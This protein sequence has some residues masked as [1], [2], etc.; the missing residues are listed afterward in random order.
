MVCDL[1]LNDLHPPCVSFA[2][3][4]LKIL[5]GAEMLI[6]AVHVRCAVAVVSGGR[7][8]LA[9]TWFGM[10]F[11]QIGFIVIIVDWSSPDGRSAETLDVIEAIGDAAKIASVVVAGLGSIVDRW[12]FFRGV[13]CWVT[14]AESIGHQKVNKVVCI[15]TLWLM[16]NCWEYF[17]GELGQGGFFGGAMKSDGENTWGTFGSDV[18]VREEVVSVLAGLNSRKM[19]VIR[20]AKEQEF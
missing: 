14:I 4:C 7:D 6:D 9:T 18:Q 5:H 20:V 17:V 2:N 13:V 1:V 3:E 8:S 10:H 11:L 19:D 16:R 12:R 15:E